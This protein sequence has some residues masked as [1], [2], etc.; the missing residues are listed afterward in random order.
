MFR[1]DLKKM[2]EIHRK[3]YF[4][5]L[6]QYRWTSLSVVFL[7]ANLLIPF[8]NIG[9]KDVS[10][11]NNE[12]HLYIWFKKVKFKTTQSISGKKKF[13][14]FFLTKQMLRAKS[15]T[16]LFVYFQVHDMAEIVS[17]VCFKNKYFGTKLNMTFEMLKY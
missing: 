7:S 5:V 12:D 6:W 4:R 13:C 9:L 3:F 10:T 8:W 2:I 1:S 16:K 14:N 15:N 17:S 11:A